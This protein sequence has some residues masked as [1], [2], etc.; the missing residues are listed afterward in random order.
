[1]SEESFEHEPRSL[2]ISFGDVFEHT[3][4]SNTRTF[5]VLSVGEDSWFE[6]SAI[7]TLKNGK[8]GLF[9]GG[10]SG[11]EDVHKKTGE[12]WSLDEIRVAFNNYARENWGRDTSR[13]IV[14]L[15]TEYSRKPSRVIN[16]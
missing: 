6:A 5:V 4:E 7:V 14:D 3:F 8:K 10:T 9:G 2:E 13:E 1:M 12:R 11:P 15:I 16:Y